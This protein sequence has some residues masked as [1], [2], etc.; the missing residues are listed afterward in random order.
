[1]MLIVNV[2]ATVGLIALATP[3]VRV[4][5]ERGHFLPVDT[6]ATAA[7]VR[8]YA[9]GLVGYSAA[10]IASPTFYALGRSRVPVFVSIATIALN[11]A[12]SVALAG[13]MGF[14]GLALATS[15]AALAN[16]AALVWLLRQYT[17]GLDGRRLTVVLGKISVA[18]AVMAFSALVVDRVMNL[19]VPGGAFTRQAVRLVVAI[20]SAL[21]VLG[22]TAKLLRIAEFD[23]IV[24]MLRVRVRKLLN[25]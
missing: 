19:V 18:A 2:P 23:E 7:A 11:V 3:I 1:M 17:H 8:L 25:R 24:G 14:R 12:L 22:M 16:G 4:L 10:R 6:D 9:L 21:A 20:G 13:A 15:I 5:F